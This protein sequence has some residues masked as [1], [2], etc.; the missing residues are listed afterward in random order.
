M[1]EPNEGFQTQSVRSVGEA[2]DLIGRLFDVAASG[3]VFGAPATS[4]ERTIITA[5]E[6]SVAMG[7]GV[8]EGPDAAGQGGGGGGFSF[9][10]PVAVV[11][12]E[13]Q[14]VRVE[15]VVDVTKVAIAMFTAL[16]AMF[17]AWSRMRRGARNLSK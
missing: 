1:N 2:T 17:I 11:I 9:G 5:S 3:A 7:A 15:P 4:G 10:R 13:P 12:V 6:L 16:G 14:G 8:G